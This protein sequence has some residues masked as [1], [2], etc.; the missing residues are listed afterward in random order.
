MKWKSQFLKHFGIQ[1]HTIQT[2]GGK[3]E[4]R[5][6]TYESLVYRL[7][8]ISPLWLEQKGREPLAVLSNC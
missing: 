5:T 4:E 7:L 1:T 8:P 6:S 2:S 3:P